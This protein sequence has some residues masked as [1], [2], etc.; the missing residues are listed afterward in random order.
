MPQSVDFTLRSL[1]R[2]CLPVPSERLMTFNG[3]GLPEDLM[4]EA[5]MF[6]GMDKDYVYPY[7]IKLESNSGRGSDGEESEQSEEE[8]E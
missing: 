1:N 2:I 4:V 7:R 6:L 3:L 8:K 5:M